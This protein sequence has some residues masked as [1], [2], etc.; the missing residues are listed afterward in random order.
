MPQVYLA[1]LDRLSRNVAFISGLMA[2]RVPFVVAELG[3]TPTRFSFTFTP[4]WG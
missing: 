3:R 1:K 4:N 2:Q